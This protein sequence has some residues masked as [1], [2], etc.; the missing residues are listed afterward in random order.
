MST[1]T[2]LINLLSRHQGAAN[3]ISARYL[4]AQMRCTQRELRKLI[5]QCRADDGIAICAHPSTGYY[6][7]STAQ[8][9]L[10]CCA[11]LEARAMHSLTLLSRMR[12]VSLPDLLG[13]LHLNQA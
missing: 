9:L 5:S 10:G 4:A 12:K 13:Q 7:A 8:E 2:E 3:G 1:K 11:F 6:I